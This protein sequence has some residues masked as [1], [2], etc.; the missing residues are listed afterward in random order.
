MHTLPEPQDFCLGYWGDYA[1]RIFSSASFRELAADG[2][3]LQGSWGT[4]RVPYTW[5]C[6]TYI[7][8]YA[9]GCFRRGGGGYFHIYA[10]W[11]CA[12]RETPIFNPKFPVSERLVMY[13]GYLLRV[14]KI[15]PKFLREGRKV[16][17]SP[18]PPPTSPHLPSAFSGMYAM[19][20][21]RSLE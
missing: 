17:E 19:L 12:A 14:W 6:Y 5:L 11:V 21:P 1:V 20:T 13:D 9:S 15:D 3:T 4:G 18:P 10:Y 16:T 7:G 8:K 2:F